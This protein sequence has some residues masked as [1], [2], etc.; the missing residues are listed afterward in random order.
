[1]SGPLSS[2]LARFPALLDLRGDSQGRATFK[3]LGAPPPFEGLHTL[4]PPELGDFQAARAAL[5][6]ELVILGQRRP[7]PGLTPWDLP[8]D[9]GPMSRELHAFDWLADFTALGTKAARARALGWF[10]GWIDRFAAG[11]G[12]GWTPD[13]V[14]RR[15]VNMLGALPFLEP[16]LTGQI[17]TRITNELPRQFAFAEAVLGTEI[18]AHRRLRSLSALLQVAACLKGQEEMRLALTSK[19]DRACEATLLPH[20]GLPSRNPEALM[21]VLAGLIAVRDVL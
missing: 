9:P 4:I 12:P 7:C 18:S 3:R 16:M 13:I 1:M 19:L 11:D 6:G 8:L 5:K 17:G 20:G 15:L 21:Y 14:A 2:L 10:L